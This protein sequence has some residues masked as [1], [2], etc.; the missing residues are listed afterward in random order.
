MGHGSLSDQSFWSLLGYADP[1][2]DADL[3]EMACEVAEEMPT[4]H[5]ELAEKHLQHWLG[6]R[7]ELLK[8]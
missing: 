4:G 6:P 1:E 7:E 3:I 2:M 8:S 5:P